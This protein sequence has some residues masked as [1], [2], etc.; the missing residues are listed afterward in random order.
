M[1]NESK[2]PVPTIVIMFRPEGIVIHLEDY[3]GVSPMLLERAKQ[4]IDRE[5]HKERARQANFG[6]RSQSKELD[7]GRPN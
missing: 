4:Q 3:A 1:P 7:N 5:I 6:T 2:A